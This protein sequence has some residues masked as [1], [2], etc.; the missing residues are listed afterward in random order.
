M[1]SARNVL[2]VLLPLAI[3]GA[4]CASTRL[5]PLATVP[6][7]DLARYMGDWYVLAHIPASIERNAHAAIES[8]RLEPDGTI[9][10]TFTFREGGLDG[11][12][13]RYT[14]RGRVV[15]Q[16]TNAHWDMKFFWFWP[17][18]EFLVVHVDEAY[19]ETIVGRTK[20]DYVWIMARTPALPDADYDR[21]VRRVGELGYD[22]SKLRR[23]PQRPPAAP[24]VSGR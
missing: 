8:Y 20:R 6:R 10:T 11:E 24:A 9:A 17:A 21:L 12:P 23:V 13:K 1:S 15:D 5:P 3:L 4:G 2:L 18:Q 22:L 14:P 16:R 19:T 7:L